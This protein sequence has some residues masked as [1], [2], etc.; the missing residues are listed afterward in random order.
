MPRKNIENRNKNAAMLDHGRVPR[1]IQV[2][3]TWV[4]FARRKRAES[5]A[6]KYWYIQKNIKTNCMT[7]SGFKMFN[8]DVSVKVV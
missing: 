2:A 3:L 4:D 7:N 5:D 8:K 1:A 6:M